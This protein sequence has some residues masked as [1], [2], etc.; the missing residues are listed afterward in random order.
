MKKHIV[1]GAALIV[2][3]LAGTSGCSDSTRPEEEFGVVLT[4]S[5]ETWVSEDQEFDVAVV[6]VEN[7]TCET[8]NY[9]AGCGFLV[10]ISI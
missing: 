9:P 3:V 6:S 1:Y 5:A 7:Y 10:G 8:I 2:V 4:L